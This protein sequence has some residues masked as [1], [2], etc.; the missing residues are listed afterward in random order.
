MGIIS[1]ETSR[2]NKLFTL[3]GL[4]TTPYRV[5]KYFHLGK[6][7]TFYMLRFINSI[8]SACKLFKL[9]QT[10]YI[11]HTLRFIVNSLTGA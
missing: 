5:Q 4:L 10:E 6:Q 7:N 11:L 1:A 3:L 9:R 2:I 8:L